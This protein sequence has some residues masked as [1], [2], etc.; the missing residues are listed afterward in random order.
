LPYHAS[1]RSKI[2]LFNQISRS[3][4]H[5]LAEYFS[6]FLHSTFSLLVFYIVFSLRSFISPHAESNFKDAYSIPYSGK[7]SFISKMQAKNT[8]LSPCL[9]SKTI[10]PFLNLSSMLHRNDPGSL[11][12]RLG[13]ILFSLAVS[14]KI[15]VI[16]FSFA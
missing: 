5:S 12:D 3:L 15:I 4:S 6:P 7:F 14:Y 2:S 13:T 9:E 8:G 1:E 16:F 10:G 11:T